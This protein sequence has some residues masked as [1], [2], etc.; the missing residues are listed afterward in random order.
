ME[1]AIV[2]PVIHG[3]CAKGFYA[4]AGEKPGAV[5][6]DLPENIAAMSAV[7]QPTLSTGKVPAA[8]E[9]ISKAT[10]LISQATNPLIMVGNGAI[11]ANIMKL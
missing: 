2:R 11:R 8:F 5:H 3:N 10:A 6:I 1:Y 7:G 9:C 4:I